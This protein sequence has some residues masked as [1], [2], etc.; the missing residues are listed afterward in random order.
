MVVSEFDQVR[1]CHW[2]D[3]RIWKKI[4]GE[5][6]RT[7]VDQASE[8]GNSFFSNENKAPAPVAGS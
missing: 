8:E 7:R 4:P 3:I 1:E 2:F 5:L 6:P